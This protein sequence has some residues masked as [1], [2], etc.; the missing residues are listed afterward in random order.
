MS[1]SQARLGD[2]AEGFFHDSSDTAMAATAY[3]RAVNE[4]DNQTAKQIDVP[5]RATVLDPISRLCANFPEVNKIID[6]RSKKL[7]DYDAARSRHK[8]LQDKPSDDPSKMPRAEKEYD[9]TRLIFEAIN[10][11][12][13]TELPYLV[14]MR[15]PY[16]DPSFEMMIRTQVR[17]AE[18]G[19]EQ[20][21]GVQRYFP[22]NVR[23]DYADG[24]LDAQV[25]SV[26]QE[27]R[28]L[29]ICGGIAG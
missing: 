2:T 17:F 16:L 13:M 6:K 20:L 7:L 24:R 15:I 4:M 9:D 8:K 14:D 18:E 3:K 12:M 28:G 27:M 10:E 25:E 11:Q 5:Y 29:S 21:G 22:E 19:Y 23:G 1:A 26:L